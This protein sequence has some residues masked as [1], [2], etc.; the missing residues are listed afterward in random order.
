MLKETKPLHQSQLGHIPKA[1]RMMRVTFK[2]K[3]YKTEEESS[4]ILKPINLISFIFITLGKILD[5]CIR[6]GVLA[7]IPLHK[8]P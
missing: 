4:K 1:W 2:T 5:R 3:P 6:D 7:I 8:N